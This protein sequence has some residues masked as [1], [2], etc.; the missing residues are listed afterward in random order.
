MTINSISLQDHLV[1]STS[2]SKYGVKVL[3][4]TYTEVD[5]VETKLYIVQ[6][7]TVVDGKW[8][9]NKGTEHISVHTADA[10]K[11]SYTDK[12]EAPKFKKGDFLVSS[13]GRAFLYEDVHTVWRV[14]NIPYGTG[15]GHATLASREAEFGKL[16]LFLTA[17]GKS[18][19]TLVAELQS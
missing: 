15:A 7:G 18:F 16:E 17:G 9:P 4:Y 12:W 11:A 5:G 3:D 6:S 8:A 1:Y 14:G 19:A 13:D 2:Y 10:L